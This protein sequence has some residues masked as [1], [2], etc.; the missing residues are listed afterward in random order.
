MLHPQLRQCSALVSIKCLLYR[1]HLVS[2]LRSRVRQLRSP[3][4]KASLRIRHQVL[5]RSTTCPWVALLV[6]RELS[7]VSARLRGA[8]LTRKGARC[9]SLYCPGSRPCSYSSSS[10]RFC[11]SRFFVPGLHGL[12]GLGGRRFADVSHGV[13][14][15]SPG[16][17]TECVVNM[18]NF[19]LY[20]AGSLLHA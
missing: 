17:D 5:S 20:Y 9:G 14:A 13:L 18:I 12:A 11:D 8:F 10:S 2:H 6:H 15:F 19:Q 1:Q 16:S 4:C 3:H 7:K